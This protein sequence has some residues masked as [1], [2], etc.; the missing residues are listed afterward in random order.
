[1]EIH[2]NSTNYEKLLPQAILFNLKE[3]EDL[4]IFK[5]PMS[6]KLIAAG[7]LESVKIGNKLHLSRTEIIRYLEENTSI[8]SK[9]K[10]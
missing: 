1:M 3:A 9:E 5:I 7:K 2:M 6:K 10:N 8:V 4:S